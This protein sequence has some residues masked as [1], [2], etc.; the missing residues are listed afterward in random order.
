MVKFATQLATPT[1]SRQ[2]FDRTISE[3]ELYNQRHFRH[4]QS[5]SIVS[6]DVNTFSSGAEG[7]I[8]R[9]SQHNKP[10]IEFDETMFPRKQFA[11]SS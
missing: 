3:F 4:H 7:V 9:M 6:T 8:A 1:H 11:S 10:S 5:A 2:F